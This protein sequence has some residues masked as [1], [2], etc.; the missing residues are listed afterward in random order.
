MK[1]WIA[2]LLALSLSACLLGITGCDKDE[3]D[4]GDDPVDRGIVLRDQSDVYGN[5]VGLQLNAVRPPLLGAANSL[6][7][8]TVPSDSAQE[9]L[10]LAEG[11][12]PDL[13]REIGILGPDGEVLQSYPEGREGDQIEVIVEEG[14]LSWEPAMSEVWRE[15]NGTRLFDYQVP[16]LINDGLT[17]VLWTECNFD[18]L[19]RRSLSVQVTGDSLRWGL[20]MIEPDTRVIYECRYGDHDALFAKGPT[21]PRRPSEELD[22]FYGHYLSDELQFPTMQIVADLMANWSTGDTTYVSDDAPGSSWTGGERAIG[23][24]RIY[25][26][27]S[28]WVL[29]LT[30]EL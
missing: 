11:S 5:I 19:T 20:F 7:G 18:T 23:W 14:D 9:I 17:G 27:Q 13:T 15:Q 10:R 25:F 16:I 4:D 30:E 12:L 24:S 6:S 8:V 22:R 21:L 26:A 1:T 2:S 3:D 29:A 28:Y